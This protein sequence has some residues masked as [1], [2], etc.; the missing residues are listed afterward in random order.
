MPLKPG[1][2]E[3]WLSHAQS[4]LALARAGQSP[5]VL[6]QMLCFHAQQAAEKALKAVLL[7]F[8]QALPRT[9]DL[10]LLMDLLPREAAMP[11]GL[12]EAATLT[13]YAVA[14]RYPGQIE[15]VSSEEWSQAAQLAQSVLDWAQSVVARRT[16]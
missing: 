7:S 9:H 4:D 8:Q 1:S 3:D 13:I 10:R 2:P 11:A 15:P 6:R 5:Q 12:R 14:A 16:R